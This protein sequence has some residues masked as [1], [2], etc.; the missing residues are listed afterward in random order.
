[1]LRKARRDA[2]L[3]QTDLETRSGIPK[4]AISMYETGARQPGADAFLRL[5]DAAGCRVTVSR[6]SDEQLRRAGI[7]SDLLRFA[8]ELP[9]RWPGDDIGFPAE[10]WRA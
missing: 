6:F 5:L 4:S 2:G 1:M 7:F 8:A 3:T 10:I 9:H